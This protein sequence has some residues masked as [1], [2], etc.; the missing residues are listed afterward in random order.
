M[1]GRVC[2]LALRACGNYRNY[3]RQFT[4]SHEQLIEQL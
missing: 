4:T 1:R 3:Q 2:T